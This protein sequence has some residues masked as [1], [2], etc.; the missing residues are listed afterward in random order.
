M[1][2]MKI[3][4]FLPS[5]RGGGAERVFINLA[6][7]LQPLV[8]SVNLVVASSEGVYAN[9]VEDIRVIDLQAGRIANA[10]LPLAAYLRVGQP[11]ILL[12]AMPHANLA[13]VLAAKLAGGHTRVVVSAHAD[14]MQCW[15]I[16]SMKERMMLRATRFGYRFAHALVGVST[17]TLASER[18]FLGNAIPAE[19]RVIH[20]PILSKD[21][22]VVPLRHPD[23]VHEIGKTL[24]IAAAGRLVYDKDYVTLLHAFARVSSDRAC[25]LVIYGEGSMRKELES[26]AANLGIFHQVSFPGFVGDLREA[27]RQADIFVLSSRL[28]GFGNVLV[29]ALACGC[30]VVATDCPNGP[31][32]ILADGK[33]GLLTPVGDPDALA[34]GIQL[35]LDGRGPVFDTSEAVSPYLSDM[36]ARQYLALFE[37]CCFD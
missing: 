3:A 10:I 32:E 16:G 14:V 9:Q 35:A 20:N 12:A 37:E 1:N 24:I 7:A 30:M 26:L 6:R 17:G 23:K 34:K 4:L 21:D 31:R 8:A 25:R 22:E 5:L 36:I 27:L 18:L 13:A 2:N 29:E 19:N 33:Y 11:T 15:R 28:E